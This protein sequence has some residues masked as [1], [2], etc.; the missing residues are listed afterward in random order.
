MRL[1][2]SVPVH[3]TFAVYCVCSH[4]LCLHQEREGNREQGEARRKETVRELWACFILLWVIAKD[5]F[6]LSSLCDF[7]NNWWIFKILGV[8]ESWIIA[9]DEYLLLVC[10]LF[11]IGFWVL[12]S[13][14]VVLKAYSGIAA[15]WTVWHKNT[16][17]RVI[18]CNKMKFH[19]YSHL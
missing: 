11:S 19:I 1:A 14:T 8:L 17:L 18:K 15:L 6:F 5:Y 2:G 10:C 9:E 7:S 13:V 16:L 12:L 4:R 3:C